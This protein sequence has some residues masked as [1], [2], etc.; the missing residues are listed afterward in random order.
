MPVIEVSVIDR[1]A[2]GFPANA[3]GD[4]GAGRRSAR[5]AE[6]GRL[7]GGEARASAI[8]RAASC[9]RATGCGA[10]RSGLAV[11]GIGQL[12]AHG[13]YGGEVRPPASSPASAASPGASA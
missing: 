3:G 11:P 5:T 2:A 8:C 9:C 12:A 1:R 10:D 13:M 6:R 7:G 4:G